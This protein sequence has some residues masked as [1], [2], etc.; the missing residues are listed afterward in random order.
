MGLF[1][2]LDPKFGDGECEAGC[3]SCTIPSV[4][5]NLSFFSASFDKELSSRGCERAVLLPALWPHCRKKEEVSN[6][7][8]TLFMTEKPNCP[9]YPQQTSVDGH[10]SPLA[11]ISDR[12]RFLIGK[13][14]Q[15]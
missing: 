1:S 3:G 5:Q 9:G 6:K 13:E 7:E 4:T 2:S 10:C 8:K 11:G 15:A 14:M 12:I